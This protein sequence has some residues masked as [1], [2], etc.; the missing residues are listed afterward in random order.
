MDSDLFKKIIDDAVLY[1]VKSVSLTG[2]GEPFTDAKL[3]EKC[4]YIRE[5]LPESKIYVSSNCFLMTPD[6]YDDVAKHIDTLKISI[7]G[8]AKDIYEKCH[9]GSL[10]RDV[11]YPNIY[12]DFLH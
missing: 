9:G 12:P 8:L 7:Y 11:S 1:D 5:K 3:F 6:K 10:K 4:E 2:F